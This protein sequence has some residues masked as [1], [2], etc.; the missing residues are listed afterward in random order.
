MRKAK[1]PRC[2][3]TSTMTHNMAHSNI[4]A[5]YVPIPNPNI[6]SKRG[7]KQHTVG[8]IKCYKCPKQT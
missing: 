3:D 7:E 5:D 2:P 8:E 1:N 6:I 4:I